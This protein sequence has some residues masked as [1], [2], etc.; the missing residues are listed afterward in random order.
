MNRK[1]S[2][3]YVCVSLLLKYITTIDEDECVSIKVVYKMCL[4]ILVE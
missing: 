3:V 4:A 2:S 1:E